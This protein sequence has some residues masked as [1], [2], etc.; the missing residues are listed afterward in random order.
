MHG[1][2]ADHE[3]QSART[4]HRSPEGAHERAYPGRIAKGRS[5]HVRDEQNRTLIQDEEQILP[6]RVGIRHV[7][8]YRQRN[9]GY[10]SDPQHRTTFARHESPPSARA[11]RRWAASLDPG[12]GYPGWA[13][14]RSEHYSACAGARARRARERAKPRR[15]RR[16][17][18]LL[19]PGVRLLPGG[20]RR[21]RRAGR[22]IG[23]LVRG[24]EVC[25]LRCVLLPGSRLGRGGRAAGRRRRALRPG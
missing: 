13:S 14:P 16:R 7:Y 6:D 3:P 9:H 22:G 1:R 4:G 11:K 25:V 2:R 17:S 20:R 21:R 15:R 5:A 19:M 18:R 23:F 8:F 10:P 24:R 12:G